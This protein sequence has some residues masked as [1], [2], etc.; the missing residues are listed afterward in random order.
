MSAYTNQVTKFKDEACLVKAL[1]DNGYT[2]VEVHEQAQTLIDYHGKPRPQ[3]A[4][5]IIR[6]IFIGGPSND[7]LCQKQ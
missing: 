2:Q 6:R 3:K 5:V 7:R 1:A 4:N